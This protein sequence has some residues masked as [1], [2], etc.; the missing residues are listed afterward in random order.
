MKRP[1]LLLPKI[2][3]IFGFIFICSLSSCS[4]ETSKKPPNIV[5]IYMD[6]LG[7]KDIG[8]AGSK[9]Y[10]TPYIDALAKG[11]IRYEKAY[12]P[13]PV[14]T[15]SRAGVLT[16]RTPARLQYTHVGAGGFSQNEQRH[17]NNNK[18][19]GVG[20]KVLE[21]PGYRNLPLSAKV[22]A[23]RLK[24]V[25]YK[26]AYFG[27]WHCGISEGCR[28]EQR[29]FDIAKG[30]RRAGGDYPHYINERAL[31]TLVNLPEAK[32]GDYLSEVLTDLTCDFIRDHAQEPFLVQLSH[33]LVHSAIIPKKGKSEK[34]KN[35]PITDQYAPDYAAM[36]ES[37]DESV[38][39]IIETL[40]K[41]GIRSNTMI[42][43]TSDNGGLTL[44]NRTSNY[45]LMGGKSFSFE[46][47]YRVPFIVN[48]P[49]KVP[50]GVLN[51]DR[52]VGM[53]IY[54]TMLEAAGLPLAP[55]E[56]ADGLSL[57]PT[58][59]GKAL[60]PRALYFHYPHYTHA[61]SPHSSII[62]DNHK[63]I[64]YYNDDEG[65]YAL[66]NLEKDPG[67]QHDLSNK[68]PEL[69]KSLD[70]RLSQYLNSVDAKMPVPAD[71]EKGRQLIE[72]YGEKKNAVN[73][74]FGA[75]GAANNPITNKKTEYDH[76]MYE[77][78][79]AEE[80]LSSLPDE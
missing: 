54:P 50:A 36:V 29:G 66:Y 43:F 1:N 57:F 33:Y 11:G 56:H 80:R 40:D 15:P 45:P 64:R 77:R 68:Q 9:F 60:G 55:K 22:Y 47:G 39:Q 70:T 63:L 53:D 26:T 14:C 46:G 74:R 42:I 6:D 21:A 37:M 30:Y 5:L 38:G 7:W 10:E 31:E 34:Y 79:K 19:L 73:R 16:G 69:V 8:V 72:R 17:Y 27:K 49:G 41:L 61:T 12:S 67:E 62:L 25:G 20:N 23:E 13:S 24:E 28:P 76:A 71:S 75:P 44:P 78:K 48:W 35:K 3:L 59:Q 4:D 65:R 52:V 32:V 51:Q 18:T 58:F 2:R